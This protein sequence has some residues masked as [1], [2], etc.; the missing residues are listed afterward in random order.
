MADLYFVMEYPIFRDFDE[1]DIQLIG[2]MCEQIHL[3]DGE[4]VFAEKQEG[5]AMYIVA[6][7]VL[8]ISKI[9][10]GEKK[11]INLLNPG[12]FFG[13]MALIDNS[14]RSADVTVR[15]KSE[16]IRLSRENFNRLKKEYPATALKIADVLLKT[17]SFR[18][19]RSTTRA[20]EN[21]K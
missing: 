17:L 6:A 15:E 11:H 21:E 5:D 20:L 18:V 19:R 16:L 13:E 10:N 3:N 9:V 1:V 2:P 8:E 12:E 7:G 4:L 14:P